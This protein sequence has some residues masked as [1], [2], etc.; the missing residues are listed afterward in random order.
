MG[1]TGTMAGTAVSQIL[2]VATRH[3]CRPCIQAGHTMQSQKKS[4]RLTGF[5]PFLSALAVGAGAALSGFPGF[6]DV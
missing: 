6:G 3:Q 1:V 5:S 4:S 2:D